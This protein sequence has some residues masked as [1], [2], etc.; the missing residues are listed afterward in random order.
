MRLNHSGYDTHERSFSGTIPANQANP[1]PGIDDEGDILKEI[2][3]GKVYCQIIDTYHSACK[4]KKSAQAERKS[5][6]Q[7][8][9]RMITYA[10][11]KG[12][13]KDYLLI[14]SFLVRRFPLT[15]RET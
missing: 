1:V 5:L 11:Q 13:N 7:K 14:I 3:P 6:K 15:R 9:G 2:I 8:E 12:R 10:P 4:S